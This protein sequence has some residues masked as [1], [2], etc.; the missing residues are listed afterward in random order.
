[1]LR[2][3]SPKKRE[4]LVVFDLQICQLIWSASELC[5]TRKWANNSTD[6]FDV[7]MCAAL[8][9]MRSGVE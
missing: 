1:M 3:D 7:L 4:S 8:M 6:S 5:S 9:L 2:P